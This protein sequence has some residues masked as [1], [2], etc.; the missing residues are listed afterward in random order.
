MRGTRI[1]I[2]SQENMYVYLPEFRRV[3]RIAGHSIRQ[4][5]MGTNIYFEDVMER[6]HDERWA[7]R[8]HETTDEAWVVDLS[9]RPG[10]TTAYSKLRLAVS[11]T[12]EQPVEISYWEGSKHVRTMRR[13]GWEKIGDIEIGTRMVYTSHDRAA[14]LTIELSDLRLNTGIA[15]STF[16]QRTLIKGF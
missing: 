9:P 5:F 14:D 11:R 13:D 1:Y 15:P 4:P 8:L 16:S 10:I 12:K 6:R 2:A 3:R 7:C